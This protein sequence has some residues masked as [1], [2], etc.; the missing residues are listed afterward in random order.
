[1]FANRKR[2]C[3]PRVSRPPSGTLRSKLESSR[4][5]IPTADGGLEQLVERGLDSFKRL[6]AEGRFIARVEDRYN[7]F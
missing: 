7:T 2:S 1:M 3:A 5:R 6:R 4:K